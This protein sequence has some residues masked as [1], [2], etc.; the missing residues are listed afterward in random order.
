MYQPRPPLIFRYS[1]HFLC[2]GMLMVMVGFMNPLDLILFIVMTAGFIILGLGFVLQ[3]YMNR[4]I[5][6]SRVKSSLGIDFLFPET[7]A[8]HLAPIYIDMP[9]EDVPIELEL[10]ED[11]I[12]E[13]VDVIE[14]RGRKRQ[15]AA[16]TLAMAGSRVIP[17]IT[18][19][20]SHEHREVRVLAATIIRYLG[21][22]G[23]KAVDDVIPLLEDPEPP[24]RAQ[25]LCALARLGTPS[26][27]SIPQIVKQLDDTNEDIL[28]CATVALGLSTTK[29]DT[30]AVNALKPLLTHPLLSIQPAAAVS[31]YRHGKTTK[32]TVPM[33]IQGFRTR[34]PVIALLCAETAGLMG[35]VAKEAIPHLEEALVTNHPIIKIKVVHALI[36]LGND[37]YPLLTHLIACARFG[38][39]YV[40]LE[41]LEILEELGPKAEPAIPAYVRMLTDKNTLNRLFAVRALSFLG[42]DARPVAPQL[43]RLLQDPAKAIVYHAKRILEKLGEPLEEPE[44]MEEEK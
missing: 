1:R 13:F 17:Y 39:I 40:K 15:D 37:P 3:I 2:V 14:K 28:T 18:P 38:E 44:D 36:R 16:G 10:T 32:N 33:L 6:Q 20:L 22:R 29:G 25:T 21:P 9:E 27:P 35:D 42:E 43:R 19:L 24:I 30:A 8:A 23:S 31:L 7:D 34:N 41:S 12:L 4:K 11:E 26:K 5:S